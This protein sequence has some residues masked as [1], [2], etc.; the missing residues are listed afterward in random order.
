MKRLRLSVFRSNLHIYAQIID[1]MI[2]KTLVS[3]SDLALSDKK[4][5]N[6]KEI[7]ARVGAL[8]AERAKKK[9]ITAVFFDR[10]NY[11]FHGLIKAL[12]DEAR[13]EGLKF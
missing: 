9:K 5:L 10:K 4:K 6:K 1:D 2:G 11:K 3:A 13:K 12:A 7:S 8:L